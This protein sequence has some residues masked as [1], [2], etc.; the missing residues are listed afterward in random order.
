MF[1][2]KKILLT[3]TQNITRAV[4]NGRESDWSALICLHQ[5]MD[6]VVSPNLCLT[7]GFV[8]VNLLR[9]LHRD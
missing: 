4:G 1:D 9:D 2:K 6:I 8:S 5:L 7:L 3:I